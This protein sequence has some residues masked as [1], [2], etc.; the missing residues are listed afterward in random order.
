MRE[1]Q[2]TMLAI[3][4]VTSADR[5]INRLWF[6]NPLQILS[7]I[8]RGLRRRDT[9]TFDQVFAVHLPTPCQALVEIDQSSEHRGLER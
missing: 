4:Q 2:S 8:D 7:K 6:G 1:W 5:V 3:S 9:K